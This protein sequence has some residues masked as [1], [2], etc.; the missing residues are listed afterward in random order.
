VSESGHA[1]IFVY[2]T[3]KRG[4]S[5]HAFLTGQTFLQTART[6]AG[7]SLVHLR[8]FPGMIPDE[9]DR[10]GVAG[11][12]WKVDANCLAQLDDLEGIN[13]GLYRREPIRLQGFSEYE[14]AQTY[15]YA[16]DVSGKPRHPHGH[17][18]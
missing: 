11:E 17:W 9:T 5:N 14:H 2:G 8:D 15:L 18:P 12:V 10:I 13:E 7:Y 16:G 6:V 1:L 3:L 4:G